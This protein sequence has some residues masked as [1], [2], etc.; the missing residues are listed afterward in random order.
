MHC[1]SGAQ[2]ATLF[3]G[4]RETVSAC[5]RVHGISLSVPT[6][7][8]FNLRRALLVLKQYKK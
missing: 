4:L 1:L 3:S 7:Q 5:E 2:S 6:R 8:L